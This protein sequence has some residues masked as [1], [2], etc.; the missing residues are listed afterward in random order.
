MNK[1]NEVGYDKIFS[2]ETIS[3]LKGKS[4]ESLRQ[5]L[6]NKNLMQVLR[7]TIELLPEISEAEAEYIDELEPLAVQMVKDA[8]PI[9]DYAGIEIDAKITEMDEVLDL[10]NRKPKEMEK[11]MELVQDIPDDKKRRII[12]GITQGASIRGAFW[13]LMFREYL[14]AINPDLIE[15]YKEIMNLTLGVYDNEQFIALLL[16][17]LAQ[18]G[19]EGGG[20][21]GASMVETWTPKGDDDEEDDQQ[22]E[23][24]VL[25]ITVRALNFPMLVYEIVKGLYEI[26]S[27]QGFGA[28]K[29]KNKQVVSR[30]D[31]LEN[32][33]DDLRYGKFIYDAISDIYNSSNFNDPRIRELLFT[34]IYKLEDEQFFP[35]IEN[36]INNNLT[37]SQKR[38]AESTMKDIESDLKADDSD[39]ALMERMQKLANINKNK[40]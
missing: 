10:L 29:E 2:P 37:P 33:P 25:K 26:V 23:E 22:E 16:A 32:E 38:W 8:Y 7:R 39:E 11:S 4:G 6:G 40:K 31:K 14:E 24:P 12:N 34:E 17:S 30:I 13:Y 9:V 21:G 20:A 1:L 19:A 28:D 5:M 3:S 35:F 18:N 15:K 27:L 36:A